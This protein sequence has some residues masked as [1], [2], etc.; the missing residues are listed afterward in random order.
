V[1]GAAP[2]ITVVENGVRMSL[3]KSLGIGIG[4]NGIRLSGEVIW[5]ETKF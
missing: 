1:E 5:F 4:Q 3:V 2:R